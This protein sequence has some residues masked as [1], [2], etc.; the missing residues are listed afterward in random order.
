MTER[1]IELVDELVTSV[2]AE[3]AGATD[4]SGRFPEATIEA[5]LATPLAGLL[6]R[7]DQGGMGGGPRAAAEVVERLARAC[8]S[9]A[10]IVTMHYAGSAVI[11]AHGDEATCRAIAKGEH[12][13][14]LAFSESGSRSHFWAP[15][16][17]AEEKGDQVLLTADKSFVTSAHHATAYVWSSRPLAAEGASTLWLVPREAAGLTVGD[18]FDGLGLRG[19]DSA[20]V[21]A[22]GAAIAPSRRLGEDGKGFD[23][24]LGTVLPLFNVLTAAV[25]VGFMEAATSASASHAAASRFEHLAS[26]L[27]ELPTI[28]AYLARMRCKTDMAR[29]LLFDTVAAIETGRDDATLRVLEA[30][31]CAGE[32]AT[33]VLD[34]GMRVCGGAAFRRDLGVE[35]IFRDARAGTIMA[36]TTDQLYDFI[37]KAICGLDVF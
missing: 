18:G 24:M 23:V 8:G 36:P 33:E 11:A 22:R 34:L 28:R 7:S 1:H 30:K 3:R 19:N 25:A 13:S 20:P 12:L 2:V 15:I 27:A 37:G 35:R 21:R 14:T 29:T 4:R 5:F 26:P 6:I 32:A 31:A 9:T 16:G 10:M 17:T